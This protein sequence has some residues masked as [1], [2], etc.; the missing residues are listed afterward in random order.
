MIDRTPRGSGLFLALA[1]LA[2]A[3]LT[4]GDGRAQGMGELGLPLGTRAPDAALEDLD[5]NAVQLLD[6][7]DGRPT[8]IEFWATWCENCEALQPQLDRIQATHGDRIN[9]VAVAVAVSQTV[10]RIKQH[11]AKHDPGYPYLYD[12]R[13]AAVRAYQV[14]TTSV[15][16]ILD[17]GGSVV[18]SGVGARQDLVGEVEKLLG[19]AAKPGT[20]EGPARASAAG[21]SMFDG[22]TF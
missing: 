10:R 2:L 15:V 16:V 20:T 11:L 19:S 8:L 22:G 6:Y 12:A 18:Y 5:G 9:I 13:G 17:A 21:P 14:P 4:P 1:V 7:V 3:L